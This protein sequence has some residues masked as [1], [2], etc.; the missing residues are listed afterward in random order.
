MDL[1]LHLRAPSPAGHRR[2]DQTAIIGLLIRGQRSSI[3]DARRA[4]VCSVGKPQLF[5]EESSSC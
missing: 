2:A 4:R 5:R 1:D 3:Y